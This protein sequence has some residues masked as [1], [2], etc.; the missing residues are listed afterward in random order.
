MNGGGN[1]PDTGAGF[2]CQHDFVN[3][4]A[5]V[6]TEYGRT[7]DLALVYYKLCQ[8]PGFDFGQG[9]VNILERKAQH[10]RLDTLL[11]GLL[12]G[13]PDPC[14]FRIGIRDPGN[15]SIVNFFRKAEHRITD[16]NAGLIFRHVGKEVRPAHIATGIDMLLRGAHTLVDL[17]TSLIKIHS[18]CL[19]PHILHRGPPSDCYQNLIGFQRHPTLALDTPGVTLPCYTLRTG[20]GVHID[21][22]SDQPLLQGVCNFRVFLR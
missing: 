9:A 7:E 17:D 22:F 20:R 12:F 13:E 11:P 5:G 4:F 18:G 10:R 6:W 1:I 3:Q 14:Q 19:Q 15:N 16:H 8:P 21:S 2:H